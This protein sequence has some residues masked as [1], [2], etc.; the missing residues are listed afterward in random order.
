MTRSPLALVAGLLVLQSGCNRAPPAEPIAVLDA[1]LPGD[2][3]PPHMSLAQAMGLGTEKP[4]PPDPPTDAD[5]VKLGAREPGW[6]LDPTDPAS[7]YAERFI[8]STERYKKERT[9][10]HAQPSRIE[11]GRTLV[12][13][14]DSSENG[15]KGTNAVRDTFAVDLAHD[16]IELAD[17]ARGDP[18]TEWPDGSRPT[19]MATP[20]PKEGPPIKEWK[21]ALPK[22]FES[23]AL[24]PLRVQFYGRG[25]YPLISIA[26]WHGT[27]TPSSSPEQL[28][29]AAAK[30][31]HASA[32]FPLGVIET[33]DRSN[34]L[35][36]KC[37]ASARWEHL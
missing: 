26:G 28:S 6:D 21:S 33:M 10:V 17:P 12:D 34:V 18:L 25:S 22:A 7:D 19:G 27:V 20:S 23:L 9:C 15:C 2:S 24:V 14:R 13:T 31:C 4:P 5:F 32:G 37:P 8:Q 3:G 1:S 29:A 35:R 11:N 16:R 30:L 36:I